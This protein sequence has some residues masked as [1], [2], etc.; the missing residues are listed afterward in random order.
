MTTGELILNALE[1][2]D[3]KPSGQHEWRCNSPLRPGSNSLGF[4]VRIEPDGEHGAY[5]DNAHSEDNGSL[6]ALADR[7][8]IQ[9]PTTDRVQV[10]NTK[11]VY[12]DLDDYA[13]AH[14]VSADVLRAAGWQDAEDVFDYDAKKDRRALPFKTAGGLR[15]RFIDG[16]KATYKSKSG[17]KSCWYGL[18]KALEL[19]EGGWKP[20]VLCNGEVSTVV[21]QHY[22]IPACCVTNGEKAIPAALMQEFRGKYHKMVL[23][24][25]DCDKTGRDAAESVRKQLAGYDVKLVDL[26]LSDAGD[27]AD[28]CMLHGADALINLMELVEKAPEPPAPALSVRDPLEVLANAAQDLSNAVRENER[29][30]QKADLELVLARL[31]AE[32]DNVR[33]VSASPALRS[34]ADLVNENLAMLE[35]MRLNPSAIRGLRSYIPSLDKAV[36]GFTPEVYALYGATSMGKSTLAVSF[37]REFV[38]QGAGLIVPTESNPN[39]WLVKLVAALTKVPSDRIESGEI[40]HD[41]YTSVKQAYERLRDHHCHMLSGGSPTPAQ[42]RAAILKGL[43]EWDYKWCVIDSASKMDYPGASSIYDITRGVWNGVQ[44]LMQEAN[45]PIIMTAQIGRDVS[46]PNRKGRRMPQLDDAY[47]AATIEQNAGVV[48]GLYNHQYYVDQGLEEANIDMFPPGTTLVKILKNRWSPGA[49]ISGV[50]LAFMEGAGFYELAK[51]TEAY[52]NGAGQ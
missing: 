24:V 31:Q 42:V 25:Y 32:L 39:R 23:L 37:T 6:Y 41:E 52:N 11:R 18:R 36:G 14:G 7:L 1:P 35:Y 10:G 20:I 5:Y 27:L 34:F 29:A 50:R 17:Y 47:G 19:V 40:S 49:R 28:F 8:N 48:L 4:C 2:Y 46:E 12:R 30:Q 33:M 44:S 16:E 38:K 43:K 13:K 9:R 3:L 26:G 22:G 51:A 21:A 15:Y 45:I